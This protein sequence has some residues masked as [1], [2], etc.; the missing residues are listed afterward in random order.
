M[1]SWGGSVSIMTRLWTG[2]A[3]FD[4]W[5]GQGWDFFFS[6]PHPDQFWGP[7]SLL[8]SEYQGSIPRSKVV[9]MWSWPLTSIQ[10]QG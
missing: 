8:P 10:F 3:R 4:S 1:G 6:S 5:T 2:Q 7:T 9:R